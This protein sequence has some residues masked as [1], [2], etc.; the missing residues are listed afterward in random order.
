MLRKIETRTG[1]IIIFA[2]A[3]LFFGGAFSYYTYAMP[4]SWDMQTHYFSAAKSTTSFDKVTKDWKTY[5]DKTHGVSF[6]YPKDWTDAP[7]VNNYAG[8][9]AMIDRASREIVFKDCAKDK[10]CASVSLSTYDTYKAD[11]ADSLAALQAIYKN[12]KV[13]PTDNKLSFPPLPIIAKSS[14]KYIE[15]SDGKFRGLYYFANL[16]Q[17]TSYNV[18]DVIIL[19]DGTDKVVQIK[20]GRDT[21]V[22]QKE[23][24]CVTTAT[25]KESDQ[26]SIKKYIEGLTDLSKEQIIT[27][28]E[29]YKNIA[30][31]LKPI[32]KTSSTAST[33]VATTKTHTSAAYKFSI[34]YPATWTVNTDNTNYVIFTSP[35][36]KAVWDKLI[37]EKAATEGPVSEVSIASYESVAAADSNTP[38]RYTTVSDIVNDPNYFSSPTA[39]T[40]AGQSAYDVIS[41]GMFTQYAIVADKDGRIYEITFNK[42]KKADLTDVQ[43]AMMASFKFN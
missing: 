21:S 30:K 11:F 2:A 13:S 22:M 37:A 40:L 8:S 24:A 15:T 1:L 17:E 9:E 35:E 4:T 25:C 42:E 18:Y 14:A 38:K 3:V 27:E 7:K 31:S 19:T 41:N 10:L 36:T 32:E 23:F 20:A 29:T 43:K 5:E 33:P 28:L 12:R 34:D 39:T 6:K 16:G 26:A